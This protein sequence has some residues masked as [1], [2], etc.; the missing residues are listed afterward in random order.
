MSHD[1]REYSARLL[2]LSFIIFAFAC[3]FTTERAAAQRGDRALSPSERMRERQMRRESQMETSM[4][5]E[6]LKRD[7]R[8]RPGEVRESVASLQLKQDFENLQTVNNQMMTMTFS[9]NVLDYKLISESSAEIRKRAARLK[10]KLPLPETDKDEMRDKSL[11]NWDEI[12]REQLRPALLF[13]D[14]LIMRFVTNPIFRQSEVVDLQQSSRAKRDL[15]AIIRLSEKIA[16]HAEKQAK[17][18]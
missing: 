17:A 6:A 13:L 4:M 15:E 8:R 5:I 14:D 12:N 2:F 11:K 3:F 10:S 1:H 18:R 9:N 16:K 7:N